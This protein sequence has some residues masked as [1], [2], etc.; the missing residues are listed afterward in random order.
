MQIVVF[1][2][3]LGTLLAYTTVA[4]CVLILRYVPPNEVPFPLSYKEAID[5]VSS[6]RTIS[7]SSEDICVENTRV[8]SISPEITPFLVRKETPIRCFPVNRNC[9]FI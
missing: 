6:R 9:E 2:V 8:Y 7:N 4:I 5:S 3:S 1:Q